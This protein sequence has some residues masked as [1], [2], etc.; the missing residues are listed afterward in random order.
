MLSGWRLPLNRLPDKAVLSLLVPPHQLERFPIQ[1]LVKNGSHRNFKTLYR[2]AGDHARSD[3]NEKIV[4]G[5]QHAFQA[6]A[7]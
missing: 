4:A 5:T 7:R 6:L 1:L 3:F 2:C